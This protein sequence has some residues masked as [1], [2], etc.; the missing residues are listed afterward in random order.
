MTVLNMGITATRAQFPL[1]QVCLTRRRQSAGSPLAETFA[2][3]N[4]DRL[5]RRPNVPGV[6]TPVWFARVVPRLSATRRGGARRA[7]QLTRTD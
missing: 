3:G 4:D 5:F 6:A 7:R 2:P 1:L